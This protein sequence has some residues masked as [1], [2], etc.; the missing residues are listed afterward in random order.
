MKIYSI[1]VFNLGSTGTHSAQPVPKGCLGVVVDEYKFELFHEIHGNVFFSECDGLLNIYKY[2]PGSTEG[3]GGRA[4]ALQI[5][6][7]SVISSRIMARRV[8]V[9]KG[10]LWS[11]AEANRAVEEHLGTK[12][13]SIGVRAVTDRYRVY[14]AANATTEFINRISKVVVLGDPESSPLL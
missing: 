12:I 10:S 1:E 4:I 5:M 7:P 14:S 2:S 8:R 11:S 3:F 9:F 6:E 13:T